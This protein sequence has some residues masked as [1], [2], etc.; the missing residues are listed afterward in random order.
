MNTQVTRALPRQRMLRR[1]VGMLALVCVL[2]G[3]MPLWR[4]GEKEYCVY[5]RADGRY[6]VVVLRRPLFSHF[7]EVRV[8]HRGAFSSWIPPGGC[9]A[10]LKLKWLIWCI[11]W[12]GASDESRCLYLSTKN[13]RSRIKMGV[14]PSR[15]EVTIG[16]C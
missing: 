10:N 9:C 12:N 16:T 2:G 15:P 4:L 7:L 14:T 8:T 13:G 11:A 5:V 6:R 3:V 1:L